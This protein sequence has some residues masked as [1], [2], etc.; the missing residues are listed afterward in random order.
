MQMPVNGQGLDG[1]RLETEAYLAL[2]NG[3]YDN[4][5]IDIEGS[6]GDGHH[7]VDDR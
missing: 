4:Q 7:A 3:E 1:L 2:L 6:G 5:F